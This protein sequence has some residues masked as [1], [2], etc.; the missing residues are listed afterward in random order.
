MDALGALAGFL[1]TGAEPAAAT[2]VESDAL[3]L[4]ARE[5][6]VAGL[7][8]EAASTTGSRWVDALAPIHQAWLARGLQQLALLDR[9]RQILGGAGLRSL[10]LSGGAV[11]ERL[12]G[13]VGERPM[14]D[15]DLLVL[16]DWADAVRRLRAA[17]YEEEE[18][19]DHA[20]T[21]RA[22]GA[23]W[24][25]ELH[26]HLTSCGR[27]F[28]VDAD[29]LWARRRADGPSTEDLLLQLSLHAAFQHG[30]V[31]SLVQ[32]YDLRRLLE[33]E[34]VD[35]ARLTVLARDL[36]AERA[37]GA[38]LLAAEAVVGA[39]VPEALRASFV[40]PLAAALRP[41]DP[42]KLISPASPDLVRVR[43]RLARG[44]RARLLRATLA[45]GPLR[46]DGTPAPRRVAARAWSLFRSSARPPR[47]TSAF[48]AV[49]CPSLED[50]VLAD[51]L[52]G[53]DRLR[54]TV[55]GECMRPSLEPGD[56]VVLEPAR[57]TRPRFGDVVLLRHPAGLRLH[58]LI[59]CPPLLRWRTKADRSP[60]CDPALRQE[61]L[62]ATVVASDPRRVATRSGWSAVKSLVVAM[63]VRAHL[64]TA[65]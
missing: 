13:G 26:R 51:C 34:S 64:R 16:D 31:L 61:D 5:Q 35:A 21:F 10:A 63:A 25:V 65:A 60:F 19:A 32:W 6:G 41:R 43:W 28:P 55:T 62:L 14:S 24:R 52:A 46:D 20:W 33:R 17:G 2:A 3:L 18:R 45:E 37:V 48:S 36:R 12:Y 27:L 57:R 42:L 23:S 9:T 54:L 30:L 39:P 7:W 29:G 44:Q 11:A 1:R 4:A 38:A 15:V 56:T 50:T 22:P 49:N 8:H 58:R 53:F 40:D 47:E 59:F